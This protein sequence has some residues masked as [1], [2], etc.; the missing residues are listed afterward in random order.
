MGGSIGVYDE[1]SKIPLEVQ[2]SHFTPA[3]FPLVPVIN[4]K[5]TTICRDSWDSI[6]SSENVDSN[7]GK[8]S[9]MTLFY[10]EFYD[11]LDKA[12]HSGS[13]DPYILKSFVG[14]N[15]ISAKGSFIFRLVNFILKIE[16]SDRETKAKLKQLGGAH[17]HMRIRPWQYSLLLQILLLTIASRL[18]Q[19]AST[20]VMYCWVNLTAFVLKEMLPSAIRG[21]VKTSD[22][23]INI[24][25]ELDSSKQFPERKKSSMTLRAP[26]KISIASLRELSN[27][28][29]S[30]DEKSKEDFY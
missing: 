12:D 16:K 5:S 17:N 13:F 24:K 28:D 11:L 18:G 9:G 4:L 19:K 26:R 2:V 6:T 8:V 15:S 10:N 7:G 3:E 27:E 23:F 22:H 14:Q 29:L 1:A 25:S 20:K 21:R 30:N